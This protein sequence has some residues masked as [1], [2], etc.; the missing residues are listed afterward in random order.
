MSDPVSTAVVI[1]V[2]PYEHHCAFLK[3]AIASVARQTVPVDFVLLVDDM[4][5]LTGSCTGFEIEIDTYEPT[6][7]LGVGAAFN[8]GVGYVMGGD[9]KEYW[10]DLKDAP[11]RDPDLI[12]MLG[13]D[14]LLEPQAI[15]KTIEAWEAAERAEGY[16]WLDVRYSDGREDQHLPCHAAAVTPGMFRRTGGFTPEMCAG[17]P[18]AALISSMM[19]HEPDL[20]RAVQRYGEPPPLYW[21]RIHAAQATAEGAAYA[22]L[23]TQLRGVITATWKPQGPWGHRD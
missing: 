10:D 18:D 11:T 23:L 9:W 17:M 20:L 7:R 16:Y 21:H 8:A 15:E 13:A 2:G 6:W 22:S 1:P 5:G 4:H 14:D 12:F 3:E 19:V